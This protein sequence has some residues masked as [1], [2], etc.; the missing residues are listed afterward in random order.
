MGLQSIWGDQRELTNSLPNLS[1]PATRS[2]PRPLITNTCL[3]NTISDMMHWKKLTN[4]F[5]SHTNFPNPVTA[6]FPRQTHRLC[7]CTL[8]VDLNAQYTIPAT[9]HRIYLNNVGNDA[10]W[11]RLTIYDGKKRLYN[12]FI[13]CL[14]PFVMAFQ[15]IT[16]TWD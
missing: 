13:I 11:N 3:N 2:Q 10:E 1:V 12:Q 16:C 4:P 6:L 15:S 8:S 14:W 7:H 5:I 9:N